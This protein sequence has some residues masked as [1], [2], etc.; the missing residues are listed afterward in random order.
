MESNDETQSQPKSLRQQQVLDVAAERPDASIEELASSIPSATPDLVERV[1]EEFGDPAGDEE[2]STGTT[3]SSG[4]ET[5]DSSAGE[6]SGSDSAGPSG[7]AEPGVSEASGA[8]DDAAV[9]DGDEIG[10]DAAA[11]GYPAIEDLPERQR[12]LLEAVAADPSAT[13]TQI[14]DR[15]DV[16]SATVSRWAKDVPGFEWRDRES[17]VD[18]VFA[19]G[20][21]PGLTTDGG[22][23]AGDSTE[24]AV[25]SNGA[26]EAATDVGAAAEAGDDPSGSDATL[27]DLEARVAALEEA[28]DVAGV[29]GDGVFEDPELVHKVVHACMEADTIDESE[30]LRIIEGL[31]D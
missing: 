6:E 26:T 27:E 28:D 16:T 9:V 18:S 12:E 19:G 8:S 29:S 5:S 31:L 14:A 20:S 7:S 24:S 13:Q 11:T 22:S 15:F 10:P 21:A 23:T 4:P 1:L 2:T 30:E 3:S 17:F 25:S